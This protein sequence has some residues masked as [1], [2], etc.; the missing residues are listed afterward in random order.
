MMRILPLGTVLAFH[1]PFSSKNFI[2]IFK[3]EIFSAW[4]KRKMVIEDCNLSQLER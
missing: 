2:S 1:K 3:V 4:R